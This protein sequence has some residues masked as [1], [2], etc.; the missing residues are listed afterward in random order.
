MGRR[1]FRIEISVA[2]GLERGSETHETDARN[3]RTEPSGGRTISGID[4]DAPLAGRTAIVTGGGT[5]TGE[6]IALL[7]AARGARVTVTGRRA[8]PLDAVAARH[9]RIEAA[10]CDATDAEATAALVE[11]VS[12]DIAVA[13]AGIARSAPFERTDADDWR[14]MFETNVMGAQALFAACLAGMRRRGSGRC[15]AIA[16]TAALRGYLYVAAYCATKHAVLGMVRALALELAGKSPGV[17]ANAVCPGYTDTPML[18]GTI[19]NVMA[20][21]GRTRAEAEAPILAHNPT[22]RFVSVDE[23]ADAVAWLASPGASAVNG[24]AI[25]VSGGETM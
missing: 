8:G 22:G 17:T 10:M 19:E 25:S 21:T 4:P 7:L 5:G 18:Q 9:E 1:N 15:I 23:V 3:E 16:S 20:R 14:A 6:A 13:N 11:R 12:P 2:G 24:Q